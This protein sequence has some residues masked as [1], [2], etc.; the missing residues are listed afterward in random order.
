MLATV[1]VIGRSQGISVSEV[2]EGVVSYESLKSFRITGP[3]SKVLRDPIN[4]SSAVSVDDAE[5]CSIRA[6]HHEQTSFRT[7]S[8]W[9]GI[10]IIGNGH[11]V[12]EC[13]TGH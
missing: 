5:V 9:A 13:I 11:H 7:P 10:Y 2:R 1:H 8:S 6:R 4:V 12:A 3:R